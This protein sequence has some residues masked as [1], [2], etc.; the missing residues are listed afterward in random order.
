M[1]FFEFF[2]CF[3]KIVIFFLAHSDIALESSYFDRRDIVGRFECLLQIGALIFEHFHFV[4]QSALSRNH[5]REVL[6]HALHFSLYFRLL[7]FQ[8]LDVQLWLSQ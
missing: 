7:A 6:A 1:L 5:K 4:S 2:E 3:G 8:L